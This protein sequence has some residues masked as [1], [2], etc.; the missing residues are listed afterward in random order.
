MGCHHSSSDIY[1]YLEGL[2]LNHQDR[3]SLMTPV[4]GLLITWPVDLRPR[5]E[6]LEDMDALIN[7]LGCC[8][9]RWQAP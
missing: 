2:H 3:L 4:D 8:L 9:W 6:I 1:L 5:H 7:R